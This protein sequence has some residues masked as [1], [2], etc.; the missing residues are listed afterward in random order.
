V[1]RTKTVR[2]KTAPRTLT[3][4]EV[5]RTLYGIGFLVRLTRDLEKVV[6]ADS[7][8]A[9]GLAAAVTA[10]PTVAA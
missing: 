2:R 4:A 8:R 3:T 5:R 1:A 9:R 10:P 6:L 7:Q